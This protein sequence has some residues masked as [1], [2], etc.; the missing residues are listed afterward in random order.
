MLNPCPLSYGRLLPSILAGG[1]SGSVGLRSGPLPETGHLREL[2][3]VKPHSISRYAISGCS[4][5][6]QHSH[7]LTSVV[8][9]RPH[10]LPCP[11]Y[12]ALSTVLLSPSGEPNGHPQLGIELCP[13][14]TT[15]YQTPDKVDELQ[16]LNFDEIFQF[17]WTMLSG[18]LCRSG[19][20]VP[21]WNSQSSCP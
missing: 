5:S 18:L 3:Q 19:P 16:H 12:N 2:R 4:L 21:S 9:G 20:T 6:S 14:R 1:P 7:P 8:Q 10:L 15:T 17:L 13:S 11:G